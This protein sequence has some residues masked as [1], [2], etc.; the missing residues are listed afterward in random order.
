MDVSEHFPVSAGLRQI[1]LLSPLLSV[2]Y[3]MCRVWQ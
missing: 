3:V 1:F 2:V